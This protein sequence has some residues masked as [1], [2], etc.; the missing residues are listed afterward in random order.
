MI[1]K[2]S[3]NISKRIGETE[4]YA[5]GYKQGLSAGIFNTLAYLDDNGYIDR[6]EFWELKKQIEKKLMSELN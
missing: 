3:T 6:S 5:Y 1:N 2:V 4:E